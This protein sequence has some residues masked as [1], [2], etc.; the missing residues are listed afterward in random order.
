MFISRILTKLAVY[1]VAIV[2]FVVCGTSLVWNKDLKL[3]REFEA[4]DLVDPLPRAR[5]LVATGEYCEALEYLAFNLTDRYKRA[6]VAEDEAA[7]EIEASLAPTRPADLAATY[8]FE[9]GEELEDLDLR[10]PPPVRGSSPPA[11]S[12]AWRR[13]P[14]VCTPPR[15]T[16]TRSP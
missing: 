12:S 11:K 10:W 15:K 9:P 4:L 13:P 14:Q 8:R 5:E 3:L 1:I 7:A 16:I 2:I 6:T